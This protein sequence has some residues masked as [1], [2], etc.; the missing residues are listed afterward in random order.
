VSEQPAGQDGATN[1]QDADAHR[2]ADFY[3]DRERADAERLQQLIDLGPEGMGEDGW[4]EFREIAGRSPERGVYESRLTIGDTLYI[5][6][7]ATDECDWYRWY[8]EERKLDDTVSGVVCLQA[9]YPVAWLLM[10]GSLVNGGALDEGRKYAEI[11][12][13]L[14]EHPTTLCEVAT[15]LGRQGETETA[16]GLFVRA[17]E[18]RADTPPWLLARAARGIGVSLVD[19]G[20]LDE[21]EEA[22]AQSLELDPENPIA[23]GELEYIAQRRAGEVGE[24]SATLRTVSGLDAEPGID[25]LEPGEGRR[26]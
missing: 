15:I 21:A 4:H 6:T 3:S 7:W 1:H 10:A 23:L 13:A 22:I 11:S 19:L 17:Y 8:Y 2:L 25:D 18:M 16:L 12:L 5:K 20:R 24:R 14:E 9:A 26:N